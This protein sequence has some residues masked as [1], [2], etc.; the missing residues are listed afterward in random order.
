MIIT[1]KLVPGHK[2][3]VATI[4]IVDAN[5]I[6]VGGEEYSFAEGVAEYDIN[7]SRDC[8]ILSASRDPATGTL[9]VAVKRFFRDESCWVVALPDG[10]QAGGMGPGKD[11]IT[12]DF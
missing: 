1:V 11:E 4:T 2:C 5:T 8:P 9:T 3:D 10:T 6:K 7:E 12:Y